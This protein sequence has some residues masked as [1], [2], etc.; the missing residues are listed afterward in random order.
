M[1]MRC[2]WLVPKPACRH[3]PL[4]G[5]PLLPLPPRRPARKRQA[6]FS[7]G[8]VRHA[9]NLPQQ[10]RRR[11]D[12]RAPGRRSSSA[13]PASAS[14]PAAASPA[15]NVARVGGQPIDR[16]RLRPRHAAGAARADRSRSAATLTMAEARQ[17]GI[18]GMVLARLVNDAALDGEAARLGLSTGDE[19]VRDQVIATPAFH[20]ADGKFD[21][22]AYTVALD[23]AGLGPADFEELLRRE[24]DAR[25]GRRRRAGGRHPAR[26][27]GADRARLPR[28]AAQLRLAPPRRRACCPSRSRRRPTPSSRAEHKAHAADRYTRPETRQIT[29]ASVTPEALAADDRD[30]RGRAPRRLRRRHRP[31]TRPRSG[32]CSTASASAPTPRP[33]RRRRGSTPARST[34]TRWP[35]SAA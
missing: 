30:P 14:A 8:D 17:Y 27:R 1:C 21:R 15:S 22:E 16:R 12:L 26:H 13:S 34:S 4:V 24:V 2:A 25:P 3:W 11:A 6:T 35:P 23:R 31:L 18:D 10:T 19:T 33:R 7:A 5:T 32:A 9:R 28:R 29:Y 20:G